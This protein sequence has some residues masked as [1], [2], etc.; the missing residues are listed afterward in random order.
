MRFT[1]LAAYGSA[2]AL[3][4]T[5]A[6]GI[7]AVTNAGAESGSDPAPSGPS[8]VGAVTVLRTAAAQAAA[9][10]ALDSCTAQGYAVTVSVVSRD[11]ALLAL[12]RNEQAMPAS[13]DSATGKAYASASFRQPSGNLGEAANTNPG[14][15]Q[16]P[17]FVV[18]R[19]GLPISSANQVVGA[20]GVGGAP[21]GNLDE[22][23]AQAGID[24]IKGEL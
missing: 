17:G 7:A 22:A 9:Q 10:A 14:L 16:M 5:A 4:T 18:L 8:G 24:A 3:A 1:R 2:A 15:L 21:G 13:V 19:G 12:L 6:L 23:C 20:I 11:G